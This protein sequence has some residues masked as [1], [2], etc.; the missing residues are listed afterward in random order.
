MYIYIYTLYIICNALERVY[1]LI[2]LS[3]SRFFEFQARLPGL[4]SFS[5]TAYF[6]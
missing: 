3:H 4:L 1:M 6:I 2:F 5:V